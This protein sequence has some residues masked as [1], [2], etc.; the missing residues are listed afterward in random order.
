MSS[1][2]TSLLENSSTRHAPLA[3]WKECISWCAAIVMAP[4]AFL[5][6]VTFAATALVALPAL[7]WLLSPLRV[8]K[9]RTLHL[10]LVGARPG[11]LARR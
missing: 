3:W 8:A 6:F 4:L 11:P 10:S 7:P 5:I 1:S 2:E 9:Q